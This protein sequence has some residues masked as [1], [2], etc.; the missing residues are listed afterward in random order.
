[1]AIAV[2]FSSS[3]SRLGNNFSLQRTKKPEIIHTHNR[4]DVKLHV[5]YN[6]IY[7]RAPYLSNYN[8]R[9]QL[10]T[11]I[12]RLPI[13]EF[14]RVYIYIHVH[15]YIIILYRRIYYL[16]TLNRY[17]SVEFLSTKEIN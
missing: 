9:G 12:R 5:Y 13:Y 14:V 8:A 10:L 4:R 11:A 3:R 16:Y 6:T 1:M 2:D 17:I 15:A 7:S